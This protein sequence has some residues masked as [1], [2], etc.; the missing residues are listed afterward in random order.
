MGIINPHLIGGR[1]QIEAL[2]RRLSKFGLERIPGPVVT[3]GKHLESSE[4][5]GY[6]TFIIKIKPIGCFRWALI[7]EGKHEPIL[8]QQSQ[9]W[10]AKLKR[11]K[12]ETGKIPAPPK[13]ERVYPNSKERRMLRTKMLEE[14]LNDKA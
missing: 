7:I 4:P 5:L 2:D 14:E 3:H 12:I 6:R 1:K 13:Q 10:K 11:W 8:M 9:Y